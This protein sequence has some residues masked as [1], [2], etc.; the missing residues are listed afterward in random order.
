MGTIDKIRIWSVDQIIVLS[1]NDVF[2]A[3]ILHCGYVTERLYS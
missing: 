2:P 1:V 3:L